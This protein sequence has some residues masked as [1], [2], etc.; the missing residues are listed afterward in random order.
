MII[1]VLHRILIKPYKFEEIDDSYK[2]A[3]SLG[4]I[5]PELEENK[6]RDAS[7]DIGTVV[8]IGSTAF[9]DFGTVSPIE[10][11]DKIVY[12]KFSGKIVKDLNDKIDYVLLN[13]E[14]IVAILK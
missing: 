11:G 9:K 1:P 8:S 6:R 3:E 14:D 4:L 12:A 7:V 13:D 2:K 10:I 5:I